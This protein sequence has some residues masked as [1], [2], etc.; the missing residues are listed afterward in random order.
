MDVLQAYLM[1]RNSTQCRHTRWFVRFT[2]TAGKLGGHA[3]GILD[4]LYLHLDSLE[5][6]CWQH[7]LALMHQ[8]L[9]T[10]QANSAGLSTA[11]VVAIG[12]LLMHADLEQT[13][14]LVGLL[15]QSYVQPQAS[16][17]EKSF[18][19]LL[20]LTKDQSKC[21]LLHR[22]QQAY[23][24]RN[25]SLCTQ[26]QPSSLTIE[27]IMHLKEAW[28]LGCEHSFNIEQFDVMCAC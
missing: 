7:L 13:E 16:G 17:V 18:A 20:G 11:A 9:H 12:R 6:S 23:A 25:M 19:E 10:E 8:L 1:V 2:G 27:N 28:C 3:A 4:G 5:I 24:D 15:V 14:Q 22:Q 21:W 26:Q